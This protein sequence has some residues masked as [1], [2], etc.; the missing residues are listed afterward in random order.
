MLIAVGL[1]KAVAH[2]TS[3]QHLGPLYEP[4]RY[5][6]DP[7]WELLS[8]RSGCFTDPGLGINLRGATLLPFA[9]LRARFSNLVILCN[10]HKVQGGQWTYSRDVLVSH[11]CLT[12]TFL[13]S[14]LLPV[15]KSPYKFWTSEGI[16]PLFVALRRH[17]QSYCAPLWDPQ[18]LR[19][20]VLEQGGDNTSLIGS[21]GGT[22][23]TL[24]SALGP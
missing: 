8:K 22:T 13:S 12:D 20:H 24:C 17:H 9:C 4:Q 10:I 3:L 14:M 1:L 21:W 11:Q 5:W 2:A 19:L 7:H 16:V 18:S 6:L 23:W 15:L